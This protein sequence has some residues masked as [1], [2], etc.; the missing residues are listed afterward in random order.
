LIRE[1]KPPTRRAVYRFFRDTGPA[2]VEVCLLALAD[3]RATYEQTLPQEVW[4]AVLEI[5]RLMLE[6]WFEK[7]AESIAP[8]LLVNGDDL[9]REFNLSPGK[10]IGE[11]L[12]AIREA[13]AMGE[14]STRAQA[15]E[16]ARKKLL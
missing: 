12:E 9:I 8:S 15:L 7:P 5:V 4:A 6:N 2:G 1:G 10:I 11:M 14:V 13:Q 16:L 3:V